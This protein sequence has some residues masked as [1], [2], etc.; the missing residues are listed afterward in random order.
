[1]QEIKLNDCEKQKRWEWER[2]QAR[3][4][5]VSIKGLVLG[6]TQEVGGT[7]IDQTKN[8]V[9]SFLAVSAVIEGHMTL[10]MMVACSTSSASSTRRCRSSSSSCRRRRM[11]RSR[12]N[13]SRRF[14]R[15]RTKS[16]PAR[17]A[18]A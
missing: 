4:F 15:K 9:I 16:R 3:L 5:Q 14:R 6:Q 17:S 8:V 1:M 18:S 12:S 2:I 7:F 10:G 11:R 13:A